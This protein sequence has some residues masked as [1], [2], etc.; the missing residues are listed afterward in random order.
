M[1]KKSVSLSVG[2]GEKLPTE[3]GAGLTGE[4]V[5]PVRV[6]VLLVEERQHRVDRL[7]PHRRGGG[8]V[9]IDERVLLVLLVLLVQGVHGASRHGSH[10]TD[11]R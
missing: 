3:R 2:R 11:E 8:V 10:A 1:A 4:P 7:P 9:E 5:R 6:R